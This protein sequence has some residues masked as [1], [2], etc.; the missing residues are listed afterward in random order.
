MYDLASYMRQDRT[1]EPQEIL[2]KK[3]GL[4]TLRP[5]AVNE[6]LIRS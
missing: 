2:V 6:R 5:N 4:C 1:R 3:K